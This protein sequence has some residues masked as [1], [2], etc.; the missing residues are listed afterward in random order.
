M[1][2]NTSHQPN[3][4]TTHTNTHEE[5][6]KE[7]FKDHTSTVLSADTTASP[8]NIATVT[9]DDLAENHG[10]SRGEQQVT[11]ATDLSVT[12]MSMADVPTTGEL[13][14][15]E[16]SSFRR[17]SGSSDIYATDQDDGYDVEYRKL[18]LER[19]ILVGVWTE[20]TTAEIEATMREL[21]ALAQTAGSE[22]V[23][24]LYQKRDRPDPGT[25]IGSGKVQELKDIVQATNIDTV[26]CD[27]ELSPGQMIALEK[28]LDVK[29]IDR[30]MLILD[31]F[32]QH[33]KS[34]EGKAQVSLAQ[35]EY[36]ITRVRGWGGAL[37][38][39]AGGRAGG[40]NGGVT[41]RSEERRVGKECRSRWS[42][43]H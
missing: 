21:A 5:L 28:A 41:T 15:E 19:V 25:Y 18:R 34:K 6:I 39:Q 8:A 1:P 3:T 24:M 9:T 23:D 4:Q 17:I 29:V 30:T 22:V 12:S 42:P 26:I 31:I 16:R 40:S 27:G 38:R 37:S 36:L 20:G 32:A 43:Y 13:D 14:L 7:A 33:A 2:K 10:V 35:M 11:A